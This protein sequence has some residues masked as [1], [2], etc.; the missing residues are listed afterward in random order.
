MAVLPLNLWANTTTTSTTT[1]T[2]ACPEDGCDA[3]DVIPV[4]LWLDDPVTL[5]ALQFDVKFSASAGAF[6]QYDGPAARCTKNPAVNVLYATHQ[7]P[8]LD[9]PDRGGDCTRLG[10]GFCCGSGFTGRVRLLTCDFVVGERSPTQSDFIISIVDASTA[11]L[12]RQLAVGQVSDT[13]CPTAFLSTRS[14][15][16]ACTR[17]FSLTSQA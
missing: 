15:S 5:G 13:S 14:A 11:S 8:L 3:G 16:L 9:D 6:D 12:R 2:L 7:A 1:S 17:P 10:V 4:Q